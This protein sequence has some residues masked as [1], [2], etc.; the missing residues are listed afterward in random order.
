MLF[1]NTAVSGFDSSVMYPGVDSSSQPREAKTRRHPGDCIFAGKPGLGAPAGRLAIARMRRQK[2][3]GVPTTSSPWPRPG[4]LSVSMA[5]VNSGDR[6]P[7]LNRARARSGPGRRPAGL[8][9][10]VYAR[11]GGGPCRTAGLA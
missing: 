2:S 11:S 8:A 10:P 1:C 4:Q 5:N 9:A 7:E 3:C 6:H